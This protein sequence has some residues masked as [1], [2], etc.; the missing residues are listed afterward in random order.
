M[1]LLKKAMNNNRRWHKKAIFFP[2]HSVVL[3]PVSRKQEKKN[4]LK[5]Q[6]N[7]KYF[8]NI[9]K[10]GNNS[11]TVVEGWGEKGGKVGGS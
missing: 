7:F 8:E 10:T 5:E 2:I 4:K 9:F 1:L 3:E 11:G 6:L